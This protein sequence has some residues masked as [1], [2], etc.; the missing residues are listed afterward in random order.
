[1]QIKSRQAL[2]A[3]CGIGV[4]CGACHPTQCSAN[5]QTDQSAIGMPLCHCRGSAGE[6]LTDGAV[7]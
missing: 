3:K 6:M 7:K 5:E 4:L 2:E 1:M